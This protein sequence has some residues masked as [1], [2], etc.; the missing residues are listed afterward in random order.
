MI[1]AEVASVR[2]YVSSKTVGLRLNLV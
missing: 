2:P 1:N